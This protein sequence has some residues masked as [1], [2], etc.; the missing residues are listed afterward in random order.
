[1]IE[2]GIF[3]DSYSYPTES[4]SWPVLLSNDV[5]TVNH[6]LYGTSVWY[7]FKLFL[8]NYKSYSHIVFTYTHSSRIYSLPPHLVTYSFLKTPNPLVNSAMSI[9]NRRE[10]SDVW[11]GQK[12]TDD[13]QLDGYL[14]QKIF[15]DVNLLCKKNNIRLI[16]ILPYENTYHENL[17]DPIDLTAASGPCI[18][19]LEAV[20]ANEKI[21]PKD[22]TPDSRSCHLS[23]E[24]NKILYQTL[25]G[26]INSTEQCIIDC[27]DNPMFVR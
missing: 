25:L 24:N 10:M 1:M 6:S 17:T 12:Y 3:G 27:K 22:G 18:T 16:N 15:D 5:N 7:S 19:G 23:V 9:M 21:Q 20:S 13:M 26:L 4:T 14:S 2:L 11:K 8:Q